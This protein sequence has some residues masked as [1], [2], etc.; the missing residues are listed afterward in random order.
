M[1]SLS[2][3]F[4]PFVLIT[5]D[6]LLLQSTRRVGDYTICDR[7]SDCGA[8]IEEYTDE[9]IGILIVIL[10]TFIHRE[11]AMAAPFLPEILTISSR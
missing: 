4:S 7:C 1:T 2:P 5:L 10:G 3:N 11:P 6:Y 9:D 8:L